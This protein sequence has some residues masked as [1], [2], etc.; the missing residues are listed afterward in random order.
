MKRVLVLSL[1][2]LFLLPVLLIPALAA[3]SEKY[4]FTPGSE[5]FPEELGSSDSI[6]EGTYI[7]SFFYEGLEDQIYTSGP[8]FIS[9]DY[10]EDEEFGDVYLFE[11]DVTF[12]SVDG[13]DVTDTFCFGLR[14]YSRAFDSFY[15]YSCL[16]GEADYLSDVAYIFLEPA[17]D[18]II[19]GVETTSGVVTSLFDIITGNPLFSTLFAGLLITVAVPIY[20][21]VKR[22]TMH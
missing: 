18:A 11:S 1:A 3:N 15:S 12:L 8:V 19:S 14:V 4:V 5:V 22:S 13:S 16:Q 10:F 7:I 9:Y 20:V 17:P 21:A 2:V 6:P